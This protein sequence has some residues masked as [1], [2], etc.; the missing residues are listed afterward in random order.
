VL[1]VAVE[2]V[3]EVLHDALAHDVGHVGLP[4]AD[5]A[6]H[7]RDPDHQ[8]DQEVQAGQVHGAARRE[9]RGVED[10]LDQDRVHDAER[11]RHEDQRRDHA[12]LPLVRP[13]RRDDTPERLA[14]DRLRLLEDQ[15]EMVP[16]PHE[17]RIRP[18]P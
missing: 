6:G 3:A 8:P 9:Q 7:D 13:E 4:H 2:R 15:P 1:Q 18:P 17:P 12:D 14:I 10:D 5:G 16:T 11:R